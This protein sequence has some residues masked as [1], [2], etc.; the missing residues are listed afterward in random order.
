MVWYGMVCMYVC[1]YVY[2]YRHTH[3]HLMYAYYV[4]VSDNSLCSQSFD[5][6]PSQSHLL[7]GE[8][9]ASLQTRAATESAIS[10][11]GG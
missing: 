8:C 11:G 10:E 5:G 2:I 9:P 3:T 6:N 7:E 1:M 4:S